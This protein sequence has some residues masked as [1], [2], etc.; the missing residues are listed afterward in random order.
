MT[1][2]LEVVTIDTTDA[3][4]LATWWADQTGGAITAEN[5]GWYVTVRLPGAGASLAFQKIDDPTPGKNRLHLDLVTDDLEHEVQRLLDAGAGLIERR[6]VS[7]FRWVTLSDPDG[8]E[9]CVS[10]RH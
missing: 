6:E 10:T 3:T 2:E 7:D 5:E 1:L 9:F 4:G 8:N